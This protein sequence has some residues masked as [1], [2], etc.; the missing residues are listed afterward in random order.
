MLEE[1]I[2]Y[3]LG[4]WEAILHAPLSF[5]IALVACCA[6]IW[7]VMTWG[8]GREMSLLRQQTADYK[9]RLSGASPDQAK[10]R[11]DDL[12]NR[13]ATLRDEVE[14]RQVTPELI[15]QDN[16]LDR[17]HSCLFL[18]PPK[19]ELWK[20][21]IRF[22]RGGD[23][24]RSRLDYSSFSG[25]IG[26]GF[27]SGQTQLFLRE[28]STFARGQDITIELVGLDDSR[29]KR[30][31]RWKVEHDGQPLVS[32][33]MHRCRLAFIVEDRVVDDF[34]FIVLSRDADESDLMLVGTNQFLFAQ[35]WRESDAKAK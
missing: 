18:G 14:Q 27:W 28:Q 21:K 5:I 12:E 29:P 4:E 13:L 22:V 20:A 24:L 31:W 7:W 3:I 9:N 16:L 32:R 30:F 11:I 17:E 35:K 2:K 34:S 1:F 19:Y 33:N 10:A 6:I 8:Y 25:G 23:K 15:N 26:P